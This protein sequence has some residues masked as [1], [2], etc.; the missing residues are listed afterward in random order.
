MDR[1]LDA[2]IMTA[3]LGDKRKSIPISV[4]KDR[5]N[6]FDQQIVDMRARQMSHVQIGMELGY[7]DRMIA[8]RWRRIKL[9]PDTVDDAEADRIM[10]SKARS[11]GEL[12]TSEAEMCE[13]DRKM[14]ELRKRG[15]LMRDIAEEVGCTRKYVSERLIRLRQALGESV[16]PKA[17][18][19]SESTSCSSGTGDVPAII[20][21]MCCREDFRSWSRTRNRICKDCKRANSHVHDDPE[22]R[23]W[24]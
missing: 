24:A 22:A 23:V 20:K 8:T 3:P 7:S 11:T 16:V 2:N 12:P 4:S 18:G 17:A 14:L 9:L 5:L 10:A 19:K 13:R 21:C 15:M 6:A 1:S